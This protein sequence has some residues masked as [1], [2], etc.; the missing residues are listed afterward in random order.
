MARGGV[1]RRKPPRKKN[2]RVVS[3]SAA[4]L[5][6]GRVASRAR[7][8]LPGA[9]PWSTTSAAARVALPRDETPFAC[10]VRVSVFFGV[11]RDIFHLLLKNLVL[12]E[13]LDTQSVRTIPYV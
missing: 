4:T 13:I 1:E 9:T 12:R 5:A 2:C 7:A 8:V 3:G 10:S 6:F 11:I